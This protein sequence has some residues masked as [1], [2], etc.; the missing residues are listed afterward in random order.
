MDEIDTGAPPSQPD[1]PA[2]DLRAALAESIAAET[3]KEPVAETVPDSEPKPERLRAP[4]GKFAAKDTTDDPDKA[5]EKPAREAKPE[6]GPKDGETETEPSEAAKPVSIGIQAPDHWSQADKQW[7]ASF[8]AEHQPAVLDRFKKMEAGFT[9][10]LQRL[11][12]Y[13]RDFQGIPEIFAPHVDGLRQRGQTPAH[14]IQAWAGVERDMQQGGQTAAG[15]V[16]GIIKAY[17]VDPAAVAAFLMGEEPAP[18]NGAAP[19]VPPE[20]A[21]EIATL[22]QRVEAR[23]QADKAARDTAAQRQ[24]DTF[25]NEKD[26]EGNLKNPFFADVEQDIAALATLDLRQ[27]KPIDLSDLYDRAIHAN[28]ETRAKLSQLE[29]EQADK[30]AAAERKA[31]TEAAKRASVSVA[32]SPGASQPLAA[33][34]RNNAASVEDDLRASLAEL[35]A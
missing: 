11:A 7:L 10:K 13:E 28:R 32:G 29:K 4:D 6:A 14:V 23:D 9:P 1:S 26:S 25:A 31:K 30:R 12:S 3:P 21:Q 22:K 5:A 2:D 33:A 24:I 16:A 35:R 8:P 19:Q 34:P 20:L 18:T 15:R 27:G 17:K